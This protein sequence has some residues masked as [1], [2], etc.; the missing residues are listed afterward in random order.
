LAARPLRAP[1][2]EDHPQDPR[3]ND[4]CQLHIQ[5]GSPAQPQA[6]RSDL[7][8]LH[9][10]DFQQCRLVQGHRVLSPSAR[11]IGV[12]SAGHH[13]V[14]PLWCLRHAVRT[15][16]LHHPKEGGPRQSSSL[17]VPSRTVISEPQSRGTRQTT[18]P[19]PADRHLHRGAAPPT[20]TADRSW[21]LD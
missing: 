18:G 8:F 21:P 12:G 13:T 20:P 7:G 1:P 5:G 3:V 4:L 17:R 14:A 11:T 19:G 15:H 2:A 9:A 6:T 16:S 10:E